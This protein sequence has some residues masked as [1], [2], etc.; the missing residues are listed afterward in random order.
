MTQFLL[1]CPLKDIRPPDR[2]KGRRRNIAAA[3]K[4][5]IHCTAKPANR[6]TLI[7]LAHVLKI[8]ALP[9]KRQG[10]SLSCLLLR[11]MLHLIHLSGAYPMHSFMM[12]NLFEFKYDSFIVTCRTGSVKAGFTT[13]YPETPSPSV[14][15]IPLHRSPGPAWPMPRRGTGATYKLPPLPSF[16]HKTAWTDIRLLQDPYFPKGCQEAVIP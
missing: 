3:R 5:I 11:T 10:L 13:D 14:P 9:M 6:N 4:S 8:P 12:F 15:A 16:M 7:P 1:P 2:A